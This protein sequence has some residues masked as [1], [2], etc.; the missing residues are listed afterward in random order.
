MIRTAM[1]ALDCSL[2]S[3][4]P[5]HRRAMGSEPGLTPE[6]SPPSRARPALRRHSAAVLVPPPVRV[7]ATARRRI[8]LRPPY[9]HV[10]RWLQFHPPAT[11]RLPP[12]NCARH[13]RMGWNDPRHR[14]VRVPLPTPATDV[15]VTA[16]FAGIAIA[17]N[18]CATTI[19]ASNV[20]P[21]C[22]PVSVSKF[23]AA[24]TYT[25]IRPDFSAPPSPGFD[26]SHGI[27][28]LRWERRMLRSR[29]ML[30]RTTELHR[31][32]LLR[33]RQLSRWNRVVAAQGTPSSPCSI[34]P[35]ATT[36]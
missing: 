34:S 33:F 24:G 27:P 12:S 29:R 25:V 6:L 9:G 4:V 13:G 15:T 11:A 18:L 21:A 26:N 1:L 5:P 7:S 20:G 36:R 22:T 17:D 31:S 16:E 19:L 30:W 2:C 3:V 8:G 32:G 35:M 10:Q 28:H 23:L 14:L